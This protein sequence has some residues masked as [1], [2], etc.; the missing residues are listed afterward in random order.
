MLRSGKREP[1]AHV[2]DDCKASATPIRILASRYGACQIRCG[3]SYTQK[4]PLSKLSPPLQP[5]WRQ[6]KYFPV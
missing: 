4:S 2:A 1:G 6:E 5:Q 3:V